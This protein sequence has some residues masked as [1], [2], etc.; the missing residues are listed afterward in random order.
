M[1]SCVSFRPVSSVC[2]RPVIPPVGGISL[3]DKSSRMHYNPF[4]D[5]AWHVSFSSRM[6]SLVGQERASFAL[7]SVTSARSPPKRRMG[8]DSPRGLIFPG[9]VVAARGE[10]RGTPYWLRVKVRILVPGSETTGAQPWRDGPSN[11]GQ[12]S[13]SEWVHLPTIFS[14]VS[15][16]R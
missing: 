16:T 4:R 15:I 10:L 13:L 12:T 14:S 9:S 11:G 3:L 5:Y 6:P 2:R 1:S 7:I 8:S